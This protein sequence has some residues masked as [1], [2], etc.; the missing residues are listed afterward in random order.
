MFIVFISS[1]G[2]KLCNSLGANTQA[3]QPLK[4]HGRQRT[5][6][7]ALP[8]PAA[9]LSRYGEKGAKSG[10]PQAEGAL[11]ACPVQDCMDSPSRRMKPQQ[12][13]ADAGGETTQRR[14]GPCSTLV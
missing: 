4:G 3:A 12:P 2:C 9:A 5:Q 1:Q 10:H 11:S 6:P 13:A 7:R 14:H 8:R